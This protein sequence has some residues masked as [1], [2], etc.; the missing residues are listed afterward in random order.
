MA[1]LRLAAALALAAGLMAYPD[2]ALE[3][4]RRAMKTWADSVAPAMFPFLALMPYL[5]C[6]EARRIYDKLL[7]GV[8]RRLFNLP[9]G[10]ASVIITGF[11]AG[12]PAGALAV[13]RV[14]SAE[15]LARGQAERLAGIVCGVSPAYALNVMGMTLAGSV[16]AGWRLVISQLTAQ[17]ITG[18]IFS[19]VFNKG[20]VCQ[21][22][23][24][25]DANERPIAAAVGAVLR[26]CGY[27]MLFSVILAIGGALAGE[28]IKY[29]AP[30]VDLPTGAAVCAENGWRLEI[31]A[32][33]LGFGGICIAGQNYGVLKPLGIRLGTYILQKIVCSAAC[34]GVCF[35]LNSISGGSKEALLYVKECGFEI[36]TLILMAIIAPVTLFFLGKTVEK[37]FS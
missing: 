10:C 14:A 36:S 21:K 26:V 18:I 5:T 37:H 19:R 16:A 7:G 27:M 32:A 34:A 1:M 29:I 33:A 24:T 13:R 25:D 9:G 23:Y 11:A 28:W 3:A 17:V 6:P 30:A 12:S 35:L 20:A 22:T 4:A 2:I 15:G 31:S 8:V